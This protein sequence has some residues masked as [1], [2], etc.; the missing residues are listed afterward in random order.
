MANT[1]VQGT[2]VD[3]TTTG[4]GELQVVA[5]DVEILTR[6]E[7]L[8]SAFTAA[9][10]GYYRIEYS[11][12]AYGVERS[13]DLMIRVFDTVGRMLHETPVINDVNTMTYDMQQIQI[14][15]DELTGLFVTLGHESHVMLSGGNAVRFD[16]DN[17]EAFK[18]VT[19]MVEGSTESIAMSQLL[20]QVPTL[21]TVF[22]QDPVEG[23][24][25]DNGKNF[26]AR[27]L[28]H[29]SLNDVE[30]RIVLNRMFPD[31]TCTENVKDFLNENITA[32]KIELRSIK[33]PLNGAMH[34]KFFIFDRKQAYIN[35]SPL[36]QEYYDGNQHRYQDFRRGKWENMYVVIPASMIKRP[37]HDVSVALRG[38]AV[39]HMY[40]TFID[41]WNSAEVVESD[42]VLSDPPDAL[43]LDPA[44]IENGYKAAQIQVVRTLPG[45]DYYQGER[46]ILEA[47]LRAIESAEDFIYIEN[48]Y[49]T[50]KAIT[51]ALI[52]TLKRRPELQLIIVV[53]LK[54]DGPWY[55][56]YQSDRIRELFESFS[57]EEAERRIGVF[58]L[59][60]EDQTA[61]GE[62]VLVPIYIHSKVAMVDDKW[63]TIGSAN[64]DGQ[65]LLYSQH[66]PS[67][68]GVPAESY[69]EIPNWENER[70][71]VEVNLV[72]TPDPMAPDQD[73]VAHLRHKIWEEH[74]GLSEIQSMNRPE[75]GWLETWQVQAS[76]KLRHLNKLPGP[77][78]PNIRVLRA[79]RPFS[80]MGGLLDIWVGDE[81]HPT[82]R[83]FLENVGIH[84]DCLD[85]LGLRD[86]VPEFD[87]E[88]GEVDY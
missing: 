39:E 86:V 21:Y 36:L 12:W 74:L 57:E 82:A 1:A 83:S 25:F 10:S 24:P 77:N 13:P 44:V 17:E 23:A 53:N 41:L 75:R 16:I 66:L 33:S 76:E 20:L 47:Y 35:A 5:Y 50:E 72:I 61:A 43:P 29:S 59:W 6:P 69:F 79:T 18:Q 2:I 80:V 85:A 9:G 11:R 88:T 45:N 30:V 34:A 48:Q 81:I 31:V 49:F 4:V 38:P 37:I 87:F 78:V 40:E 58:T 70:R 46:G 65:G 7:V 22:N 8:G 56:E 26:N 27:L 42:I 67:S 71:S 63:A 84:E 52:R 64:L 32:N 62:P 19:D 28:S 73:V 14:H 55:D 3:N 68:F 60:T 15:T 51:T 54:V